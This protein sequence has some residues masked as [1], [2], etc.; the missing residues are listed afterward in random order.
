MKE[1]LWKKNLGDSIFGIFSHFFATA[2]FFQRTQSILRARGGGGTN[3]PASFHQ[4][5]VPSLRLPPPTRYPLTLFQG[6]IVQNWGWGGG[7][8][9]GR[10][11]LVH[12]DYPCKQ[13]DSRGDKIKKPN[14]FL[15]VRF[16]LV[17][18]ASPSSPPLSLSPPPFPLRP[19][20]W[21][22]NKNPQS[23]RKFSLRVCVCV[24]VC[25]VCVC[26]CVCVCA[27]TNTSSTAAQSMQNVSNLIQYTAYRAQGW[28]DQSHIETKFAY[29][30]NKML[31][32]DNSSR[33]KRD[34]LSSH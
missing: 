26:V 21:P 27:A 16:F 18:R 34:K 3:A 17:H 10:K 24:C 14:V 11:N 31:W 9:S 1:K 30:P 29:Y 19:L 13:A 33:H 28:G 4:H 20:I 8:K 15:R 22:K 12:K 2:F 7:R 23:S 5:L 25:V 32:A 6:S